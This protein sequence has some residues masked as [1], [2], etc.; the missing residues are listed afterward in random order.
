MITVLKNGNYNH[1]HLWHSKIYFMLS[2][3]VDSTSNCGK[4]EWYQGFL[5]NKSEQNVKGCG[6][7]CAKCWTGFWFAKLKPGVVPILISSHTVAFKKILLFFFIIQ[8][9]KFW[10]IYHKMHWH[11]F[12]DSK[13]ESS[14]DWDLALD[15]AQRKT[16]ISDQFSSCTKFGIYAHAFS[17]IFLF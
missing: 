5:V 15:S 11:K 9:I 2:E 7:D 6:F 12:T 8:V 1:W 16:L 13:A 4:R 10:K 3:T 17:P 14:M